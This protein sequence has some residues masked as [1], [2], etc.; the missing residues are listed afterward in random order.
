LFPQWAAALPQKT[1]K[2]SP[3]SL[4]CELCMH[5]TLYQHGDDSPAVL[6]IG[7][8]QGDEPGGFSAATLLATHYTITRGAV[9]IVPNLNFPSIVRN[10]RG[11]HGDMNRKFLRL[12]KNDPEYSTVSRIQELIRHPN[13]KLVLNL[14]DGSGFFRPQYEDAL[15]NPKRWGQCV[16]IDQ[17]T[18]PEHLPHSNLKAMG[19]QACDDANF[20]FLLL[21][22]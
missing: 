1:V 13:V 8:I 5:F 15:R 14:H 19:Q 11:L 9:W 12:D 7:G 4:N 21:T 22:H 2:L 10:T 17:S 18:I 20:Q 3:K 6:V 16:I